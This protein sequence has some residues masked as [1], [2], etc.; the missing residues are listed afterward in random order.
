[1]ILVSRTPVV[2]DPPVEPTPVPRPQFTWTWSA[3]WLDRSWDLTDTSSPVLKLAGATG[4]GQADPTHWWSEAPTIDG[5]SWE[6]HRT[7][8]GEVFLPLLVQGDDYATFEAEH[9]A[10]MASLNPAREGV[11]RVTR[12]NGQWREIACRYASGGDMTADYDVTQSLAA[13]YG[14]TWTTADPFWRGAEIVAT[15]VNSA[16]GAFY[17][18]PP[19]TI[20][21]G[22]TMQDPT[23]LNPGDVD[24]H[25]VWRVEGPFT[26]FSV[27][28]GDSLVEM[29]LTKSAG[30]YVEIDMRPR[31]LTIL[32][33]AGVD[34]WD[35]VTEVSF[36][37]IPP[38]QTTLT[39]NVTGAGSTSGIVLT[40]T[41]RY[42]RAW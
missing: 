21:P 23:I 32:D 41:P 8:S 31:R 40:F 4:I 37:A 36:S 3:D 19:F 28:I 7:A 18:G 20:T 2:V 42:R 26:G 9:Q 35:N 5:A 1:M 14:I 22:L 30:Q 11:L 15:F 6:G 16:G 38:G 29:T 24:A 33:E 39:T 12:P 25:P 17:P 13:T 27:G 34:R 10:F